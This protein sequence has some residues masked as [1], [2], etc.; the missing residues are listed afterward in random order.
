MVSLRSSFVGGLLNQI[1][2]EVCIQGVKALSAVPTA[3]LG[4]RALDVCCKAAVLKLPGP[5]TLAYVG[6]ISVTII[7]E[8]KTVS[9]YLFI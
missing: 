6:V 9:I 7:C 5:K 2:S 1:C 3:C 8:I 4:Y